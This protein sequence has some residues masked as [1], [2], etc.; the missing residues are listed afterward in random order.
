MMGMASMFLVVLMQMGFSGGTAGLPISLPPKPLDPALL[1]ATPDE[2]IVWFY[3]AGSAEADPK[4][5][6][7]TERLF[8]EP[9][10]ATF[11]HVLKEEIF[12]QFK[13]DM[14][15]NNN[16]EARI[17]EVILLASEA[18][19]SEPFSVT[20]TELTLDPDRQNVK[21]V[22]LVALLKMGKAKDAMA[23]S[24]GEIEKEMTNS[25]VPLE[26]IMVGEVTLHITAIED[27]ISLVWG[28]VGEYMV[29][30]LG[31]EVVTDA[32]KRFGQG[33][34]GPAWIA[35]MQQQTGIKRPATLMHADADKLKAI[36]TPMLAQNPESGMILTMMGLD[37]LRSVH[38]IG[39]LDEVGFVAHTEI[40][41][42]EKPDGL[43]RLLDN[44]PLTPAHLTLI[45]ADASLA[46]A[47]RVKPEQ[48]YDHILATLKQVNPELHSN[49]L[50]QIEAFEDMA[51]VKLKE[52]LLRSMGDSVIAYNSPGDGGLLFTGLTLV[53]P[54][55]DAKNFSA[56]FNRILGVT[57]RQE[58]AM[59]GE[60]NW[61]RTELRTM[62]YKGHKIEYLNQIGMAEMPFTLT[63]CITDNEFIFA[64]QPQMVL[65][66][67]DRA[68]AGEHRVEN[69][70]ASRKEVADQLKTGPSKLVFVDTPG[71][72]KRAYPMVMM[73]A[74][75][76]LS[77]AQRM[78]FNMD[79]SMIPSLRSIHPHL[80][81]EIT[82]VH[83]GEKKISMTT[84]A[85]VSIMGGGQFMMVPL[86][87]FMGTMGPA[88]ILLG[89]QDQPLPFAP[90]VE[91]AVPAL[92]GDCGPALLPEELA[93]E[94]ANRAE[95]QNLVAVEAQ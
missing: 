50:K 78:G 51:E 47:A 57:I 11:L 61:R 27:D 77:G 49:L 30:G 20:L 16:A 82:S 33:G 9:Q 4:S 66:F 79:A 62:T 18:A 3:S 75:M 23:K 65:S 43:M 76:G 22:G 2:H 54:L 19:L 53:V 94:Q 87:L 41:F 32:V 40:D 36:F 38:S 72:L 15:P 7:Q 44:A 12:K 68:A 92:A 84:R 90:A 95:A 73:F 52:Q 59:Q 5:T 85:T 28:V 67:I 10:V 8:A 71:E 63:W 48:S 24:I 39:G 37:H 70:I 31:K 13:G 64:L 91:V 46:S 42:A 83:V 93:V 55:K 6:N 17:Q 25:G 34:K 88:A 1:A 74:T 69:S 80:T 86:W 35:A 29:A 81:P 21:S 14:G 56:A 89:E 58:L 26:K 60:N 45:P